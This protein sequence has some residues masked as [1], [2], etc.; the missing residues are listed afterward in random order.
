MCCDKGGNVKFIIYPIL[1][2]VIIQPFIS[3]YFFE[4]RA[5]NTVIL[6]SGTTG[7]VFPSGVERLD[8]DG[9]H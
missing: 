5:R 3:D 1:I 4:K 7:G 9:I 8:L 6:I 2:M